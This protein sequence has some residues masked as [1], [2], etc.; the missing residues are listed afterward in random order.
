LCVFLPAR[1]G[2]DAGKI[3]ENRA[4]FESNI[5]QEY[6]YDRI[7]DFMRKI[8]PKPPR[9]QHNYYSV[10]PKKSQKKPI[11][12][13]VRNLPPYLTVPEKDRFFRVCIDVRD[14]AIFKLLYFCGLRVSEIGLLQLSDFRQG[15][16]LHLD[17]LLIHRLKGSISGETAL[18]PA[19]AQALRAWVRKRGY[20]PGC[21]FPSRQKSPLS[22]SRIFR[23]MQR[24]CRLAN[25][26]LEKSHPH[27][28]KH[29]TCVHLLADKKEGLLDVQRH[30]GH[31][32][33]QSTMKYLALTSE[34]DES[35]VRRLSQWR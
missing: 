1:R 20:Q 17:R 30:V 14:R 29:T 5:T 13:R 31:S 8:H 18:V 10:A 2:P 23:L 16:A 19:A 6:G 15:S 22:R 27:C 9:A 21:L 24:Y 4:L 3:P 12:R 26:P 28:W 35:R 25:I 7:L 33:V 32:S 11:K 34:Y